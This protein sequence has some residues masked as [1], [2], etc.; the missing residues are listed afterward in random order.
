MLA[1]LSSR[2]T[3]E[4][5]YDL[6]CQHGPLVRWIKYAGCWVCITKT[7]L[8]ILHGDVNM[9]VKFLAPSGICKTRRLSVRKQRENRLNVIKN[10]CTLVWKIQAR[11]FLPI[12]THFW[13][14]KLSW[15]QR[16]CSFL[17]GRPVKRGALVVFFALTWNFHVF[18]LR[19][20]LFN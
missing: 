7:R 14:K 13:E 12:K 3:S 4:H 16:C 8:D 19:W 11:Y 18:S 15:Q 20:Y 5:L 17:S 2:K 10:V 9:S 1:G 6:F